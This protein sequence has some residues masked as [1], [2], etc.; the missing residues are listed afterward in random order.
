MFVKEYGTGY[1]KG[2]N[3]VERKTTVYGTNTLMSKFF[4]PAG[5]ELPMHSHPEEQTGCLLSGKII[6]V[7]GGM[8][9]EACPGDSWMIP[10][11][12]KH[13]GQALKDSVLI[14]VFSPVREDYIPES[15]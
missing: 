5:S 4:L 2:V 6:L 1:A 11:D 14:E 8:E 13:G 9:H 12:I 15:K 7:V 10:G 3:G